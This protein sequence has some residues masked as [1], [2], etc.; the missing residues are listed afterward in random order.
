LAEPLFLPTPWIPSPP[1]LWQKVPTQPG[2]VRFAKRDW[3]SDG[4]LILPCALSAEEAK[5]RH[6]AL[7]DYVMVARLADGLL[8][9]V[10]FSGWDR[11]N[12]EVQKY[13]STWSPS[14]SLDIELHGASR[15]VA[16]RTS[17][18]WDRTGV[19]QLRCLDVDDWRPRRNIWLCYITAEDDEKT[20]HDWRS[21]KKTYAISV[22]TP[23]ERE[24]ATLPIPAFGEY[25]AV[26]ERLRV[27]LNVA[28]YG[29][30]T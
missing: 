22:L 29:E 30:F 14:L 25:A 19:L 17:T 11:N 28:G 4:D 20:I 6:E 9:I 24:L 15:F 12:P 27:L 26:A 2:E 21:G 1:G 5:E 7:E 18:D 23:E 10:R 3:R 13:A 16:V 8:L